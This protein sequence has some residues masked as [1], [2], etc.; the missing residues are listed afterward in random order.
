MRI[1]PRNKMCIITRL[2][3]H[4]RVCNLLILVVNA[5]SSLQSSGNSM[6]MYTAF[7]SVLYYYE[8]LSIKTPS[9]NTS[10]PPIASIF[11]P[12]GAEGGIRSTGEALPSLDS[13]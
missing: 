7:C 11:N 12:F 5:H 1:K 4:K 13:M 10:Q 6:T 2:D 3:L 9:N 8:S